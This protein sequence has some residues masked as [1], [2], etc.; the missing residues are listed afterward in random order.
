MNADS[1][2]NKTTG[3]PETPL[4]GPPAKASL[5]PRSS[6]TAAGFSAAQ[7][8]AS[9][10]HAGSYLLGMSVRAWLASLITATICWMC[11]Q[12]IEVPVALW[13]V[14]GGVMTYFFTAGKPQPPITPA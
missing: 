1:T 7:P 10:R 9:L 13:T 4:S 12:S 8:F 3:Q 6:Q 11:I 14:F 5:S 2:D